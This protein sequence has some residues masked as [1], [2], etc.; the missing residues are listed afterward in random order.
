MDKNVLIVTIAHK[1]E[2]S[3][4]SR[5]V[6]VS[7][8][9]AFV[10]SLS[11][12]ET[13]KL[14]SLVENDVVMTRIADT[15]KKKI[16]STTGS[17]PVTQPTQ[18]PPQNRL[19]EDAN[20]EDDELSE[21]LFNEKQKRNVEPAPKVKSDTSKEAPPAAVRPAPSEAHR[22][23]RQQHRSENGPKT[24]TEKPKR[25]EPTPAKK[26]PERLPDQRADEKAKRNDTKK[27]KKIIYRPDPN[28]D[29][30]KFYIF[31]CASSPLWLFIGLLAV[32]L[33]L[34]VLGVFCVS[35]VLLI[36]ALIAGTAVGTVVSLIGLVYGATQLFNY[37]PIG[38][39]EIGLGLVIGGITMLLGIIVY[40]VAIRLLPFLIKQL[41]ALFVFTMRKCVELYFNVK[42]ACAE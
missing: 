42:G 18:T 27:D 34:L 28:A 38:M 5:D 13:N 19:D 36:V 3:G 16:V 29:Y 24:R 14:V 40:N 23:Q 26:A 8:S 11:E 6:A 33:Y 4:I 37:A 25:A 20:A 35:I 17:L 1:L 21:M 2:Q 31:L 15:L 10:A 32:T 12:N 39:Y 22:Q 30:K 9:K 41:F 7:E